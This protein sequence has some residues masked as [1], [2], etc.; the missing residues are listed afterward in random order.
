[1]YRFQY[2]MLF[3]SLVLALGCDTG[4]APS[5]NASP[6][7]APNMPA[8]DAGP[9]SMPARTL[10]RVAVT[11][12]PGASTNAGVEGAWVKADFPAGTLGAPALS[13]T[14]LS[15]V[16][17]TPPKPLFVRDAAGFNSV[18]VGVRGE[19]GYYQIALDDSVVVGL[20]LVVSQMAQKGEATV[21]VATSNGAEVSAPT[22]L[23]LLVDPHV[24]VAAGDLDLHDSSGSNI[25]DLF[26]TFLEGHQ[27]SPPA[28]TQV[29]DSHNNN[30]D[31]VGGVKGPPG[32]APTGH[33]EVVWDG[34][35]ETLRNQPTFNPSFFDRSNTGTAGVR[36][37]IIFTAV[38]GTGSQVNDAFGGAVPDPTLVGPPLHANATLGGDFS[39]FNVHYAGNLLSF[40]QSAQFAP[41]GTVTTDLTFHVAGSATPGVV[42]GAGIV[43]SSVDKA[44]VTYL[45]FFDEVGNSIARV[46]SPAQ[47]HGPFPYPGPAV[48]DKISYSFVGYYDPAA[49]I[50]RVRVVNGEVPIN[51]GAED[52][53]IGT[54]DVVSFDDVYYSE[55]QP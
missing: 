6:D 16:P 8:P 48:A 42:S 7:A 47:S 9:S 53:P 26:G 13:N 35:P 27:G 40:T 19:Y 33:R 30:A 37:G 34:V 46:Y 2:S 36:G 55:P 23:T 25:A 45:E 14:A 20:D 11:A 51:M 24:F 18:L 44:N 4:T 3:A 28:P 39:N 41:L 43:F 12:L 1:M 5:S 49:R 52:L 32:P 17:G 29:L 10:S 54:Q 22:T 21:L 50:A 15:A 38:G 31:V